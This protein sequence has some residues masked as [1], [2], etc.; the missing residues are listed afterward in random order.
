MSEWSEGQEHFPADGCNPPHARDFAMLCTVCFVPAQYVCH[1][2]SSVSSAMARG[3]VHHDNETGVDYYHHHYHT[4]AAEF[5][6]G[7]GE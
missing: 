1:I 4:A 3:L 5:P 6:P 2:T 7:G